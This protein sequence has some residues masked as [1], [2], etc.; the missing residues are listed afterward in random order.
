MAV[1]DPTVR[2]TH[3]VVP[4]ISCVRCGTRLA[5]PSRRVFSRFTKNHYCQ[6]IDG[7]K[8]KTIEADRMI[9]DCGGQKSVVYFVGEAEPEERPAAEAA[10][11][12]S[13]GSAELW[14]D[15]RKARPVTRSPNRQFGLAIF[16]QPFGQQVGLADLK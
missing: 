11:N 16:A 15:P 4:P 13:T 8:L 12:T 10:P 2:R 9:L 5:D 7:C 1:I 6:D 3:R 14:R